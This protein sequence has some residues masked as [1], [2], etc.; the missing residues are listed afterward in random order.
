IILV[1]SFGCGP[2]SLVVEQIIQDAKKYRKPV[3][4][5][6]LDENTSKIN[7]QTRIEAF[8]D[9]IRARG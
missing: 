6:L 2:D 1:S 4:Q 5:I 7:I 8:I 9:M 3:M